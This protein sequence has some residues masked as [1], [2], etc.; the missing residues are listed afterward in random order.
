MKLQNRR[1]SAIL[2]LLLLL[3]INSSALLLAQSLEIKA[4]DDAVKIS[5]IGRIYIDGA[6]FVQDQSD[7]SNGVKIPDIR[8]GLAAGYK[9][10]TS[11]IDIGFGNGKV[12]AKDIFLQYNFSKTSYLRAGHYKEPFGMDRLDSSG[13]IKFMTPNAASNAFTPGRRIGLSYVGTADMLW[14]SGGLFGDANSISAGKDGD[15]GYAA[16][17]RLVFNPLKKQGAILHFGLAATVRKA[18]ANGREIVDGV[19]QDNART[20][21]YS[22]SLP[23]HIDNI[24]PLASSISNADYEAKYAV[25][26]L[27]ALG[28][29]SFQSEYFHTNVKRYEHAPTY[30]AMGAYGQ[31]GVLL[32]GG[33][34]AYSVANALLDK[35]AAGSLEVVGRFNYTDLDHRGSAIYGGKMRDWSLAANYY[36]NKYIMF[37]LNY[38]YINMGN[39]NPALAGENVHAIQGRIQVT[40]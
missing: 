34:Y 3:L 31:V 4:G 5:P 40:F 7:L 35:V 18:D 38:S 1:L 36:L 24:K 2:L 15:D 39:Y 29:V 33:N 9:Q 8:L 10:W 32:T 27:A 37:R 13:K 22:S 30:Q 28:P 21:S 6:A 19:L 25:E 16:T 23:S 11:K 17:G 12:S 14:F 26:L 20:V